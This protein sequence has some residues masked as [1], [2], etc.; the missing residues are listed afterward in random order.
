LK[1]SFHKRQVSFPKP[2]CVYAA[3]EFNQLCFGTVFKHEIELVGLK[4]GIIIKYRNNSNQP[5]NVPSF[6]Q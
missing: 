3:L 4:H 1:I 2:L 6:G 5:Y